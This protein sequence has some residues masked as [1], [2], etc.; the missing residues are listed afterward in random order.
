MKRARALVVP[1]PQ[2]EERGARSGLLDNLGHDLGALLAREREFRSGF[3]WLP[4]AFGLGILAYFAAAEEPARWAGPAL[5]AFSL[6]FYL[7][8]PESAGAFSRAIL[9]GVTVAAT[10]FSAASLRTAS[11]ATPMLERDFFGEIKGFIETLDDTGARFRLTI[12][13][14]AMEGITPKKL[15]GRLR[16]GMASQPGIAPGDHIVLRVRLSPPAE[17]AM[18]GGYDFRR[19]AFFRGIGGV[20]YATGRLELAPAPREAPLALRFNARIDS[21]RNAMTARIAR[22]IG[23]EAGALSAA[24]VTG[25]RGLISEETNEDLRASGLYHIVSIS[26]LH[27]VLAAG[28]LF[29]LVR[30]LLAASPAVALRYPVKKIAALCAMAGAS[31]YCVFSGSEVA[32]ERSLIMT[33]VML[34]A[35]L[36]DRPALAMRNLA[37]AALLVMAREPESLLGPSFQMSFAAVA[38]LIAANQIWRDRRSPRA[39]LHSRGLVERLLLALL[40]A[41]AGIVVTTLVATLATA[42][43][44]AFHFHRLNPYGLIG[45]SLAIPLVS[46]IVMP[47]A[48]AGT[49]LVPFGFDGLIWRLMGEGVAGVL[50]VAEKVAAIEN[51]SFPVAR[52]PGFSFALLVFALLLAVGFRTRLRALAILP[53]GVWGITLQAAPLPDLL[54]DSSGRMVLI[55]GEG[56]QYRLL[57]VG[58]PRRFTLSQWLPALGDARRPEDRSL[59]E[60]IACDRAGCVGRLMDGRIVVLSNTLQALREDCR[61]ADIVITP[62]EAPAPCEGKRVLDKAH[63]QRFGASRIF[64]TNP[65]EWRVTSSLAPEQMRPWRRVSSPLQASA[66]AQ[67][68][69]LG[70]EAGSL[71]S[72]G[73]D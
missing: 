51:A 19:E 36:V 60:G 69:A 31:F 44:S 73:Q 58:S 65:N 49:L 12:A 67:A 26:G 17:A 20:G 7:R 57:S 8:L 62:V 70:P 5:A 29:W 9:L 48:V 24:L 23:G 66:P 41:F 14:S 21:W 1:T 6:L 22:A 28:V 13:P 61:R 42:P 43:F 37:L 16:V 68:G 11:V 56:G 39:V 45:N 15:P 47:A 64:S 33:L 18:P 46:L 40:V 2:A 71:S 35:I 25:K 54:V 59:R 63:F 50:I 38:S 3:L 53:L 4:V 34:G 30:A 10:G 55:R 72:G 52:M 32:T 27:M